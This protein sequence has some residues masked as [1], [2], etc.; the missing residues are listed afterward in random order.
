MAKKQKKQDKRANNPGRPLAEAPTKGSKVEAVV[1]DL[2]KMV[3]KGHEFS[4]SAMAEQHKTSPQTVYTAISRWLPE[5]EALKINRRGHRSGAWEKVRQAMDVLIAAG[6]GTEEH[7]MSASVIAELLDVSYG[8][9]H[10]QSGEYPDVHWY[11]RSRP[12]VEEI[13]GMASALQ[14]AGLA[15]M[16]M[17]APKPKRKKKQTA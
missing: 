17:P 2:R 7:P 8:S 13:A 15:E 1:A 3:S 14:T 12:P 9:V 16:T 10:N 4:V 11:Y 5:A 6:Y